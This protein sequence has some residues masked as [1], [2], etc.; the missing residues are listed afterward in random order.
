MPHFRR[1][2][3]G[4]SRRSHAKQLFTADPVRDPLR[5][6]PSAGSR[7]WP[8]APASALSPHQR[9]RRDCCLSWPAAASRSH[10]A[11]RLSGRRAR[12]FVRPAVTPLARARPELLKSSSVA[13]SAADRS[14][15]RPWARVRSGVYGLCVFAAKPGSEPL[16]EHQRL[17]APRSARDRATS[18]IG[19]DRGR[20]RR[21]PTSTTRAWDDGRK[22][23]H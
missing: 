1:R 10:G 15:R 17:F 20:D 22:S 3:A 13:D 19:T 18:S 16:E 11:A 12:W 4:G 21:M 7:R 14:K 23:T 8:I 2:R 6:N 5:V 9:R